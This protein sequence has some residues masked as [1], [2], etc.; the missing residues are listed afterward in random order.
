MTDHLMERQPQPWHRPPAVVVRTPGRRAG[1]RPL[2]PARRL[3]AGLNDGHSRQAPARLIRSARIT[4]NE[5]DA[6]PS[7][8]APSSLPEVGV[9]ARRLASGTTVA[10]QDGAVRMSTEW[11]S[12]VRDH[13]PTGRGPSSGPPSALHES[14]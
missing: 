11:T 7:L 1:S 4:E 13:W 3:S 5:V 8:P 9:L 10:A 6:G 12:A 14:G 2:S